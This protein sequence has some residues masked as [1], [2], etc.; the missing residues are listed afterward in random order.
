MNGTDDDHRRT[1]EAIR[2]ALR[3]GERLREHS[4]ILRSPGLE[5]A[6]PSA[7]DRLSLYHPFAGFGKA[8]QEDGLG[9]ALLSVAVGEQPDD[10]RG[11][12]AIAK[13]RALRKYGRTFCGVWNSQAGQL[14][15]ALKRHANLDDGDPVGWAA[16]TDQRLVV[17]AERASRPHPLLGLVVALFGLVKALVEL[18]RP[19][20]PPPRRAFAGPVFPVFECAAGAVAASAAPAIEHLPRVVLWFADQSWVVVSL[21]A[22]PEGARMTD[23]LRWDAPR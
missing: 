14:L 17:F 1:G 18:A 15:S 19:A 22:Q 6:P 23:A 3:P 16:L 20:A 13:D 8:A 10:T 21:G 5:E 4:R 9:L 11:Q 7:A 12:E 2:A